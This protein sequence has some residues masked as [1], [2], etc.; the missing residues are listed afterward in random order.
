MYIF[1]TNIQTVVLFN[2][3]DW[4]YIAKSRQFAPVWGGWNPAKV[5][6]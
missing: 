1:F 6:P 2:T 4:T 3:D 5:F